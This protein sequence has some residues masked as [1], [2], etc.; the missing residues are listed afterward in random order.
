[1]LAEWLMYVT[2]GD[3]DESVRRR[4]ARGGRL[5]NGPR[6]MG[7]QKFCVIQDPAGAAVALM[8]PSG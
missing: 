8:G 7:P 6:S 5:V 1:M 4:L 3:I 2:V